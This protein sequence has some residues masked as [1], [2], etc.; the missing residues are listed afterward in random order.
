M[1]KKIQ[2]SFYKQEL[3]ETNFKKDD[4]YIIEKVL[5]TSNDK[6]YVKWRNY[7]SS[8]NSWVNKS[9]IKNIYEKTMSLI[10]SSDMKK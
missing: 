5:K 3:Q 4:L 9:D 7:D 10:Y 1:V 6:A 2:G 8:F